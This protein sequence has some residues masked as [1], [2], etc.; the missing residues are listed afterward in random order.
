LPLN[1]PLTLILFPPIR[2]SGP[3][4]FMVTV[5]GTR[6]FFKPIMRKRAEASG[7][8]SGFP[9]SSPSPQGPA[10]AVESDPSSGQIQAFPG[11]VS[12]GPAVLKATACQRPV[13]DQE[14]LDLGLE[15]T[16]AA[17]RGALPLPFRAAWS[18]RT[19]PLRHADYSPT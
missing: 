1:L 9:G 18:V 14:E 15:R 7:R 8:R 19:M 16:E 10:C 13:A 4:E 6:H 17:R 3:G 5:S 11:L 2:R 12:S